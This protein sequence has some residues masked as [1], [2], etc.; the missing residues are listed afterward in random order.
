MSLPQRTRVFVTTSH[1]SCLYMVFHARA[2]HVEGDRDVLLIDI[3]TRSADVVRAVMK[4]AELHDWA[5]IHSFSEEVAPGHRF[6]PSVRKRLTRKW[7][8]LPVLSWVYRTMLALFEKRRDAF[9]ATKVKALLD[10]LIGDS[11]RFEVFGL[12]QTHLN[13][14]ITQLY[15]A[16][17]PSFLEHGLGDY[18]YIEQNGKLTG[19]LFAL[20]AK[21]FK[22]YLVRKGIDASGVEPLRIP[23]DFRSIADHQISKLAAGSASGPERTDR[24]IVLI[25]LEAVD[26]YE[27]PE[28]FWSA[29]IDHVL[30]TLDD[31][32]R[33]HFLLKPHP[34]ASA[35]SLEATQA[36]CRERGVS[37]T[38]LDEPWQKGIA[39]EVL[40]A[41]WA[42]RTEHV[43]CLFSSACF[44]LS[45]LFPDPRIVYHYSTDFMDKW[46]GNA[47]PMYKRHFESLKPLIKE[48]F[49]ERCQ[50][51]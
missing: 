25:L 4:A 39:A 37:F 6:E 8:E 9:L 33:Y 18:H 45:Q 41:L 12:T 17:S 19:P 11:S 32:G 7:K 16:A 36:H 27:V 5:L 40:F 30:S 15:P 3:G 21:G 22:N 38:L 20:F 10:P 31:P 42:D 28:A 47:P 49:A 35:V 43:F 44:Y 51:Y 29:Y 2:T 1:I 26:M 50:P 13:K 23:P 24:P 34:I 48:V 46:T 14:L